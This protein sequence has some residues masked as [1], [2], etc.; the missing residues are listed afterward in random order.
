MKTQFPFVTQASWDIMIAG[1]DY[2]D[3]PSA[4][5][6]MP[7][8]ND[9]WNRHQVFGDE[10]S[11]SACFN[12]NTE[13]TRFETD[14]QDIFNDRHV[15]SGNAGVAGATLSYNDGGSRTVT[16][17]C[18]GYYSLPVSAGWSGAVTPSKPGYTFAPP[19]TSYS[20][21][22]YS[23]IGQDYTATPI[24]YTISGNVGAA[25]VALRY[26]GG[27]SPVM[28]AAN[29]SY[30]IRVSYDWSGTVTPSKTGYTFTPASKS[31]THLLAN[32]TAQN[33]AAT[34][35]FTSVAAQDGWVL[36]SSE[37]SNVGGSMNSSATTLYLGDDAAKK[38][39]RAIL[40]F[41]TGSLPD[42]AVIT[43]V[44][45][46][47]KQQAIIGGGNPVSMFQG[48][49]FDV[50]NGFFGTASTLQTGDFQ[51]A[52][53]QSYGPPS[54]LAPVGGWYSFNLTAGKGYVNKLATNSGLTQIRLRFKLDDNNNAIANIL[55]LY[56]GNTATAANRP[57]LVITYV[58][59]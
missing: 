43:G 37:A 59:P 23:P 39:Y 18:G 14:L 41:S 49:M 27:S 11:N 13:T 6:F 56:S 1:L 19:S 20:S 40:S 22:S 38:Q 53:S 44:T 54:M 9:S 8:F 32:K 28:S 29:G 50:R 48:F 55:S 3:D 58:V 21:L 42:N 31:Y 7:N 4:E 51:A 33:Y 5:A 36:E 35:T 57:Q 12:V 26:T 25:G 16:A 45:L 52:A 17:N 46:K 47:V 10:L 34:V 24:T 2:P 30:S 15:L